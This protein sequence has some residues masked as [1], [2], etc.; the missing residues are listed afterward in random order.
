[1]RARQRSPQQ[2]MTLIELLTVMVITALLL[3]LA[4]PSFSEQIARR[5]IEGI[6]NELSADLQYARLLAVSTN[7]S[8]TVSR[9]SD[10]TG[11]SISQIVPPATTPTALK[12]VTFPSGTTLGV[13]PGSVGAVT[14]DPLRGTADTVGSNPFSVAITSIG[15]DATLRV[16]T[17]LMGRVRLCS[18]GASMVGYKD[19]SS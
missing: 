7:I 3:M 14:F 16:S 9:H 5:R 11:Y 10:G 8:A 4:V 19:C 13:D 18:P 15:S 1:M 6:A 17:N 2:G 12:T